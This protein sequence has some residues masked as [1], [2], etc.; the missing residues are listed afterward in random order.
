MD[1]QG[2]NATQPMTVLARKLGKMGHGAMV[3]VLIQW[4]NAPKED[5]TWELYI[6]IEQKFPD[7]NL[8]A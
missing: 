2:L 4:S 3:Y 6:D 5:A 1:D 7:F 8:E